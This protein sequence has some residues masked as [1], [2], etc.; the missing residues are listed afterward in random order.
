MSRPDQPSLELI[1]LGYLYTRPKHGYD[2][3]KEFKEDQ[4]VQML[5]QAKSSKIYFWLKKF[6]ENGYLSGTPIP[7]S[8]RPN[9]ME[10]KLTKAG[11]ETFNNWLK[12][13]VEKPRHMRMALL[14]KLHFALK[15]KPDL[16]EEILQSQ[17]AACQD[18]LEALQEKFTKIGDEFIPA[19][20]MSYR[21]NQISSMLNWIDECQEALKALV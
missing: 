5:W 16:A 20:I 21:K 9:R 18:W 11:K 12:T 1:L 14:A 7:G 4:A 6:E 13:P 8:T 17:R 15:V 19:Q 2:L 3:I 10:Y